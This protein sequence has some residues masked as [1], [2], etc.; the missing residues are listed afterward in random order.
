MEYQWISHPRFMPPFEVTS[1]LGNG[2]TP[3]ASPPGHSQ[4]L[5]GP[6][7]TGP[8][9]LTAVDSSVQSKEAESRELKI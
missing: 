6:A 9:L 1:A 7:A 3:P 2:S 8:E 5:C 4:L